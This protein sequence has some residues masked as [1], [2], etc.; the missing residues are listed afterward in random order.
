MIVMSF[1]SVSGTSLTSSSTVFAAMISR[2]IPK[3]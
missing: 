2:K 1:G 3:R